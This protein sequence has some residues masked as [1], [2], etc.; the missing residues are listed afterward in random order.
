MDFQMPMPENLKLPDTSETLQISSLA[1]LKMLKH[2][3]AGIPLE[4]MGLLLGEFIDE[5]TIKVV[6]VFSMPQS[7]SS[8]TVEDVDPVYQTEMMDLLAKTG[9]NESV[10]GWYHSHPGFGCWLSNLDMSTQSSFEQL[11]KRAVAVVIDPIQSVKGKVVLDAFR[12]MPNHGSMMGTP[13]CRETTSNIGY[14]IPPSLVATV[15]GLGKMYY[16]FYIEYKK[17]EMEEKMLL[18]MN[19]KSWIDNLTLAKTNSLE[20]SQRMKSLAENYLKMKE[21]EK[22]LT[23][24]E[25]AMYRI[26]KLD[27]R[28]HLL[29]LC[30]ESCNENTLNRLLT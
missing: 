15:H 17:T 11:N 22:N 24:E 5:F 7:G 25:L 28:R 3:R 18:N 12:L 21:E 6:D 10:V 19:K 8:V 27:Y 14:Y 2:G 30:E 29:E 16:S 1:L 9:R 20:K 26:G 13:D 23:K 4:V